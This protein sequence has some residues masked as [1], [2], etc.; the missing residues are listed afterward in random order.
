MTVGGPSSI[1]VLKQLR[2]LINVVLINVVFIYF[3]LTKFIKKYELICDIN[4]IKS[5]AIKK[6]Y[7]HLY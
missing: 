6:N 2:V 7:N 4:K 5:I 3:S 1:T